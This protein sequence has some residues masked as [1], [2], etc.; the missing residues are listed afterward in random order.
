MSIDN[1]VEFVSQDEFPSS[2]KRRH[3]SLESPRPVLT[4]PVNKRRFSTSYALRTSLP[5]I[6]P[7]APGEGARISARGA[8]F[9]DFLQIDHMDGKLYSYGDPQGGNALPV[10]REQRTKN[11]R[12]AAE[13]G[14]NDSESWLRS[15][16]EAVCLHRGEVLVKVEQ[17]NWQVG[18]LSGRL[19]FTTCAGRAIVIEGHYGWKNIKNWKTYEADPGK[20]VWKLVF[21]GS[22]LID[23]VGACN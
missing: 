5:R 8:W 21:D 20:Q 18:F 12:L 6:M 3:L 4:P 19:T 14:R 23:V 13:P 11:V 15:S 9:V 7:D 22:R 17:L 16:D 1:D 10:W 2:S